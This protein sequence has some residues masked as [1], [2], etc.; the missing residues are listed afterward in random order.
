M[1]PIGC[2]LT[3]FSVGGSLF[4]AAMAIWFFTY[5]HPAIGFLAAAF[6]VLVGV[7][8]ARKA[9]SDLRRGDLRPEDYFD[10]DG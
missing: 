9:V 5:R 1:G 2:L 7:I 3:I 8:A 10:D 4:L 6:F